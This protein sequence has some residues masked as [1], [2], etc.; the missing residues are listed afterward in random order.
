MG[1]EPRV[2]RVYGV[3]V[4]CV[5]PQGAA[6]SRQRVLVIGVS[7]GQPAEL[8][9]LP[10]TRL[11]QQYPSAPRRC[12]LGATPTRRA[13]IRLKQ[14]PAVIEPETGIRAR[15]MLLG[16]PARPYPNPPVGMNV[17]HRLCGHTPSSPT[18]PVPLRRSTQ[19]SDLRGTLVRAGIGPV[20]GED[21]A[22][23]RR[24]HCRRTTPRR[25]QAIPTRRRF[26]RCHSRA[27]QW[28]DLWRTLT[29]MHLLSRV[30]DMR[31]V[32]RCPGRLGHVADITRRNEINMM[33]NSVFI[34]TGD[35]PLQDFSSL[36]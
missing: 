13:R 3:P 26:A 18:L 33:H 24:G 34:P 5:H 1:T 20:L 16:L 21:L 8:S 9:A 35:R 25:P 11:A 19:S 29:A 17:E 15:S 32:D 23:P 4:A 10:G 30:T 14:E 28:S 2:D 36:S 6:L 7:T 12:L 31:H 22:P 27:P